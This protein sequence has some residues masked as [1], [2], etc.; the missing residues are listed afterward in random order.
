MDRVQGVNEDF[1]EFAL[2]LNRRTREPA[3]YTGT[4]CLDCE[5]EIPEDRR[6][7]VPGCRRCIS[8]QEEHELLSHWRTP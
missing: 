2:G 4:E 8:C 7:A 5:E 1:Q 6:K 3:N